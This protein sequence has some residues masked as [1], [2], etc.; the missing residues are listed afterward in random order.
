MRRNGIAEL[1]VPGFPSI[2]IHPLTR[3]GVRKGHGQIGVC[4]G[5][6]PSCGTWKWAMAFPSKGHLIVYRWRVD[7]ISSCFQLYFHVCSFYLICS[8]LDFSSFFRAGALYSHARLHSFSF[9]PPNQEVLSNCKCVFDV[10]RH[11]PPLKTFSFSVTLRRKL[12][13]QNGAP[14][15]RM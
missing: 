3:G 9:S 13:V 10:G 2:W 14:Q 11:H 12:P 6:L 4:L 15:R 7:I 5:N 8:F 1:S